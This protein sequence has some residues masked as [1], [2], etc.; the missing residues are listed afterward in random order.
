MKK[1]IKIFFVFTILSVSLACCK[2]KKQ[3][4][5]DQL[6]DTEEVEKPAFFPVTNYIKGQINQIP[7]NPLKYTTING[8]TDSVWIKNEEFNKAFAEF[9]SPEIDSSHMEPLFKETKFSDKTLGTYTFTYEPKVKLPEA[10]TLHRW[11]VYVDFK[12]NEVRN[13]FM[14]KKYEGQTIQLLWNNNANCKIV[15]I[16]TDKNGNPFVDKEEFIKWDF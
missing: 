4:V 16:N 1:Q 13:I 9:L 12:T 11:D 7:T 8:K 10:M 5:V 2:N 3:I 6:T 15:Y 14:E